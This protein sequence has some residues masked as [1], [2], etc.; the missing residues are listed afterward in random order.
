MP[1]PI[2]N[3]VGK[4]INGFK[5]KA[6]KYIPRANGKNTLS[7]VVIC[8]NC[9]QEKVKTY[10]NMRNHPSCECIKTNGVGNLSGT[11]WNSIKHCA[12]KRS[13][14]FSIT[15]EYAWNL[16]QQQK[17]LC[18][19]SGLQITLTRRRDMLKGLET[20]SLDRIDSSQGY[21]IG[22]VQ[23]V[24][25]DVNLMKQSMTQERL[26]SLCKVISDKWT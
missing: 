18:A 10:G 22:N 16:F 17:G 9:K 21:V 26:I 12:I 1:R 5:V 3:L 7:W 2:P 15:K 6:K 23:W 4:T 20:A 19:I 14:E 13:I 24:H 25:K 8:P 11:K